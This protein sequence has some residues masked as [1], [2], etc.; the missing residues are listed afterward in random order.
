MRWFAFFISAL[1]VCG[2]AWAKDD[3]P[4]EILS[5]QA[6]AALNG[7]EYPTNASWKNVTLPDRAR[8]HFPAETALDERV[9]YNG[10]WY[11]IDWQRNCAN[12]QAHPVALVTESIVLAGEIYIN[13]ELLWSDASLIEPMSR[14][15]N[16]PR[17]LRL[18]E[19]HLRDGVNS[20]RIRVVSTAGQQLGLGRIF[21]GPTSAM[22]LVF[23]D[24]WWGNRTLFTI[25]L[26]VSAVLGL[27]FLTLW[28]AHRNETAYGWYA[29]STIFWIVFAS[30]ILAVSPWPFVSSAVAVSV[31]LIA[32]ILSI[33]CFCIFSWRLSGL[34]VPRIERILWLLTIILI[35]TMVV[36]PFAYAMTTH[37][38][39]ISIIMVVFAINCLA[40]PVQAWRTKNPE[41]IL[42]ALCLLAL[43]V[44]SVHDYLMITKVIASSITI[45]PYANIAITLCLATIMGVRHAKNAR[46]VERFQV[47]LQ[48]AVTHAQ[49]ELALNLKQQYNLELTNARLQDRLQIAHDLHDGLGGSLLHIMAT[50][51]QSSQALQRDRVL[52]MLKL[53]RDDLRQTIDTSSSEGVEAPA[54][55]KEWI[56]P[57]RHRFTSLFDHFGIHSEW[58]LPDEWLTRPNAMQCLVLTR[59]VEEGLTNVVR[60]SHAKHVWLKLIQDHKNELILKIEDDGVGFDVAAVRQSGLSVGIRSMSTRIA[61]LD[62]TLS[63]TSTAGRTVLK[64]GFKL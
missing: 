58:Q 44:C 51:E 20:F 18:S 1:L 34:K 49:T 4:V 14:S 25:N 57:L 11:R 29:L 41:H 45:M 10:I 55:P 39:V 30:N 17:L 5:I 21:I 50:V 28:V 48:N 54:S 12:P 19:P 52:S 31:Y 37:A 46:R 15:W 47:E 22:Q 27:F 16:F 24:L 26:I 35:F 2:S 59:L 38:I 64:V 56:A 60:H 61:K 53:L 63:I 62:G 40:M 42:L 36:T 32:L 23:D 43:L 7:G 13:D 3:C 6:A 9:A 8:D 33:T